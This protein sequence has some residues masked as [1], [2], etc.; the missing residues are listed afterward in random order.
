MRKGIGAAFALCGVLL[1]SCGVSDGISDSNAEPAANLQSSSYD[2]SAETSAVLES[3]ETSARKS[4]TETAKTAETVGSTAETAAEAVT[5]ETSTQ[6]NEEKKSAAKEASVPKN[7]KKKPAVKTYAYSHRASRVQGNWI[8]YYGKEEKSLRR[9]SR[10]GDIDE[11]VFDSGEEIAAPLVSQ[12]YIYYGVN[13][14]GYSLYRV[15]PDGKNKKELVGFSED[16]DYYLDNIAVYDDNVYYS[17]HGSS[18][19]GDR[20]TNSFCVLNYGEEAADRL[21]SGYQPVYFFEDENGGFCAAWRG[22]EINAEASEEENFII[23]NKTEDY[24]IYRAETGE[25][26]TVKLPA[27]LTDAKNIEACR[28]IDG[29]V[30][31]YANFAAEQKFGC[32]TADGRFEETELPINADYPSVSCDGKEIYFQT[33]VGKPDESGQYSWINTGKTLCR[34][35]E[36]STEELA[37][38]NV[39]PTF[40]FK[41]YEL[42]REYILYTDSAGK[43]VYWDM[44]ANKRVR[45]P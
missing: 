6:K 33:S 25:T 34:L 35:A 41:S 38:L 23:T 45:I 10:S 40:D 30:W 13:N 44:S 14:E 3:T 18:M 15:D 37:E 21:Y 24:Y 43:Q 5:A 7:E 27:E 28:Y 9:I 42:G 29:A 12:N 4:I 17:Y 11:K 2:T 26:E 32:I 19:E 8:Y 1:C 20:D 39:D 16:S 22:E 31:V 36:G